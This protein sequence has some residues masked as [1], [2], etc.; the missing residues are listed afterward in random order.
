MT[1]NKILNYLSSYKC[2]ILLMSLYVIFMTGATVIEKFYSTYVAQSLIYYSPLF[3]LLQLLLVLNA[4]CVTISKKLFRLSA[5]PYLLIH[6]S[7]IIILLGAAVTHFFSEEGLMHIREGET[8]NEIVL[9]KSEN[10]IEIH[11]L[12]FSIKLLDF[13]LTRY[14]GSSSPSS[15]NSDLE[16]YV[17]GETKLEKVYMNNILD[18]KG[19]RFFQSSYDQD[20]LGT[21][22]SVSQDTYGRRITYT[23]YALLLIGLL[24]MFFMKESRFRRLNKRLKQ[25]SFLIIAVLF[26]NANNLSAKSLSSYDSIPDYHSKSFASLP[27]LSHTGRVIPIQTFTNEVL[28]K[29]HGE[30]SIGELNSVEFTLS[31]LAQASKW[32]N[33]PIILV[34]N[35]NLERYYGFKTSVS[36]LDVFDSHGNYIL[37]KDLMKAYS[38]EP[39]KRSAFDKELLKLDEKINIIHQLFEH[40]L[41]D[42]LQT[43]VFQ[44]YLI[45]LREG[46]KTQD[47]TNADTKLLELRKYQVLNKAHGVKIS[48]NKLDAEILYNNLNIFNT[49]RKIYLTIGAFMLIL[50]FIL[51]FYKAEKWHNYLKRF[52]LTLIILAFIYHTFG[53]GL[54]WYIAGHSPFS[55]SY[56]TMVFLSWTVVL[57]G[58]LFSKKNFLAFSLSTILAGVILFVSGLSWMDPQISPLVP[59]L[60]SPWLM[61]HVACLISSYGFL[62]IS[63]MLATSNLFIMVFLKEDN[64]SKLLPRLEHLSIISEMSQIIG[65]VLMIIGIFI[66]AIW[67]NESWGRYWSWDPKETWALISAVVYAILLHSHWFKEKRIIKGDTKAYFKSIYL[68]NLGSQWAITFVLMTYFGVNY[69]LSGMHSYGNTTG[70]AGIPNYIIIIAVLFFIVPGILSFGRLSNFVKNK[71]I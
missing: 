3:I 37:N 49:S 40:R 71:K 21:I 43:S 27:I 2:S 66:G 57:G 9:K 63:C 34:D 24:S 61:A 7:F 23:G 64:K 56:E 54:R 20:E 53:I 41:L 55:N 50:S 45:A 22:L 62:G 39:S 26:L 33:V 19:Y 65:L 67:A 30:E 52:M 8:S 32:V 11:K 10:G 4:V 48:K 1:N 42:I 36:Y 35:S 70:L 31:V 51:L 68:Y 69:L 14:P 58:L 13:T 59:V 60:K 28:R 15:Y 16:I 38:K 44:D 6:F 5:L 25:C 29:L 46:I 47:F 17:D 18:L 12:P